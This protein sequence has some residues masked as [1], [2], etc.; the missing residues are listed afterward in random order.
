[1]RIRSNLP[2]DNEFRAW[3]IAICFAIVAATVSALIAMGEQFVAGQAIHF[4]EGW[5]SDSG[6]F[7]ISILITGLLLLFGTKATKSKKT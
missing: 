3:F 6:Y 4:G 7:G 2:H 1:M 5:D